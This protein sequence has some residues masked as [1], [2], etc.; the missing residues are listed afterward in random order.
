MHDQPE[1]LTYWFAGLPEANKSKGYEIEIFG[2]DVDKWNRIF[3]AK[4]RE[5]EMTRRLL[6]KL[7]AEAIIMISLNS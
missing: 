4:Q 1:G 7:A 2:Y 6:R 3:A 5:D